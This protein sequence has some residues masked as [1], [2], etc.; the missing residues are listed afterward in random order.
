MKPLRVLVLTHNSPVAL[1]RDD[2]PVGFWSYAV[3]DF[4]WDIR[5][6]GKNAFIDT[7]MTGYDL[8]WE[9]DGASFPQYR[10]GGLPIVSY[11]VDSTLS[12]ENHFLP[13]LKQSYQ[14]DLVL[15]DHDQLNRFHGNRSVR[16]MLHCVNDRVFKDWQRKK[17]VDVAFHCGS[18][19]CEPRKETRRRLHDICKANNWIYTSGVRDL[20]VYAQ[21]MN[22][23]R[24]VVNVP[25]RDGNRPHR[26]FDALACWTCLMTQGM[27]VGEAFGSLQFAHDFLQWQEYDQLEDLLEKFLRNNDW[28]VIADAGFLKVQREH[29]WAIRAVELRHLLN[30]ELHL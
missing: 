11:I 12:Y 14:A 5:Y 23:A 3:P 13:R 20:I 29:T 1:R 25:R 2:R 30:V 26:V 10:R 4:E 21:A 24:I 18:R 28:K 16:R 22:S 15:V 7:H 17:T 9:E 6:A 8:I 19:D 27:H